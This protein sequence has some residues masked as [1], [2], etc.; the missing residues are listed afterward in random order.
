MDNPLHVEHLL[1][2]PGMQQGFAEGCSDLIL[3]LL[4]LVV[5]LILPDLD[6]GSGPGEIV[7]ALLY[8]ELDSDSILA[9]H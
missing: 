5:P 9:S 6:P 8:L 1:L 4:V 2:L 7:P 3:V